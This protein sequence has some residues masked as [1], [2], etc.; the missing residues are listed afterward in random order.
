[1][2]FFYAPAFGI[3][4]CRSAADALR[5]SA[6]DIAQALAK[7][8]SGILGRNKIERRTRI[9]PLR[10]LQTLRSKRWSAGFGVGFNLRV[11]PSVWVD[12]GSDCVQ[13]LRRI[14]PPVLA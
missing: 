7:I 1:L 8:A 11:D 12:V 13:Y 2:V 14:A 4:L 3:F 5:F 10:E 9:T 6:Q